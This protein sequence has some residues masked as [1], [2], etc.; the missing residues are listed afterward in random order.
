VSRLK[1]LPGFLKH[2]F[3]ESVNICYYKKLDVNLL[4]VVG[5]H[6]E[7]KK[8]SI[9][10]IFDSIFDKLN[11]KLKSLVFRLVVHRHPFNF[12][13]A[14]SLSIIDNNEIITEEEFEQLSQHSLLQMISKRDKE[15]N[16]LYTFQPLVKYCI[17]EKMLEAQSQDAH[18]SAIIYYSNICIDR[19]QWMNMNDIYEYLEIFYHYSQLGEY[20]K[21]CEII[22]FC[23]SFLD[24]YGYSNLLAEYYKVLDLSLISNIRF[25]T[26]EMLLKMG[27]AYKATR[28]F[29]KAVDSY[30]KSLQKSVDNKNIQIQCRVLN[31]LASICHD[32][33]VADSMHKST[34]GILETYY[35]TSQNLP[36]VY[37][38]FELMK[39]DLANQYF[40]ILIAMSPTQE[41]KSKILISLGN[42]RYLQNKYDDCIDF[43]EESLDLASEF[44]QQREASISLGNL[45]NA[46]FRKRKFDVSIKY[47]NQRL[48]LSQEIGDIKGEINSLFM[49]SILFFIKFKPRKGIRQLSRLIDIL[50]E[51]Q[52]ANNSLPLPKWLRIF[53][54]NSSRSESNV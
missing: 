7:D 28:S 25:D 37:K 34:W 21:A 11:P 20:Q 14:R 43:Y 18:R 24:L 22:L 27:N 1:L 31:S 23:D 51:T 35:K 2:R 54:S 6:R 26:S 33:D 44:F 41:I 45:G 30:A 40:E 10:A 50:N 4:Q 29:E 32:P 48:K 47:H 17:E 15:N 49:L 36:E 5:L 38:S 8:S 52:I 3:G 9:T 19:K 42:A 53:F 12:E 39:C 46:Y 16:L 13:A